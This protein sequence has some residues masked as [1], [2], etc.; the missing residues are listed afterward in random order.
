MDPLVILVTTLTNATKNSILDVVEV[1][2]LSLSWLGGVFQRY[3]SLT[4]TGELV[5]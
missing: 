4:H 3:L 5:T 2:D 1:T